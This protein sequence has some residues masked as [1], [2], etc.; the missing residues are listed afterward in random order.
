[1]YTVY[2]TCGRVGVQSRRRR[3]WNLSRL[4]SWCHPIVL[5]SCHSITLDGSPSR[6]VGRRQT[7]SKRVASKPSRESIYKASGGVP[8]AYRHRVHLVSPRC[9]TE[10][11]PVHA[12]T[13]PNYVHNEDLVTCLLT[14]R[15]GIFPSFSFG[16]NRWDAN[17][18]STP[19]TLPEQ[20]S[21]HRLVQVLNLGNYLRSFIT[22][23]LPGLGARSVRHVGNTVQVAIH[24]REKHG[25][26]LHEVGFPWPLPA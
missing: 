1:M 13:R 14:L 7:L 5:P 11:T 20:A 9:R 17:P 18:L 6:G 12:L 24:A 23:P 4:V 26:C 19:S 8:T 10:R 15:Y 3:S 16:G 25:E 21:R 2:S 22:S